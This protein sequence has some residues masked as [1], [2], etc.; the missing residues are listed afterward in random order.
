[1]MLVHHRKVGSVSAKRD[2]G[3]LGYLVLFRTIA[4]AT[5]SCGW[6]KRLALVIGNDAYQKVGKL[7][8]AGNHA[9][10]M[11]RE[12]KAAGFEVMLL[13][14]LS[15][16]ALVKAVETFANR[17][18]GGDQVAVFFA[19][20]GVQIKTGSFL[21]SINIEANS[22]SQVEKTA[23]EL[24]DLTDKRSEAKASFALV[25]DACRDNPLKSKDGSICNT[26]GLSAIEPPKG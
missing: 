12:L 25:V 21:L 8:K 17:I 10:V 6:Q 7:E 3:T 15:Y 13:R 20:H 16:L 11:A 19:G 23:H 1:M 5:H 9:I 4:R 18:N 24:A 2:G 26:R 22:E 14:D